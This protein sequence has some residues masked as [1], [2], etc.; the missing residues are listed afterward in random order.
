MLAK[1][2]L[3]ESLYL[4]LSWQQYIFLYARQVQKRLHRLHLHY[5]K[6]KGL[7]VALAFKWKLLE[8]GHTQG[9]GRKLICSP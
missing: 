7:L 1:E 6:R 4:I 5:F 9:K 2:V 3:P 8:C